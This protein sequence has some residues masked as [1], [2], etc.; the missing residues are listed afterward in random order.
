[1]DTNKLTNE[2]VKRAIEALQSGNKDA[3]FS[4]FAN[5]VAMTDDGNPKNFRSFFD[6]ALGKEYFNTIDRVEND[7]LDIY[8]NFSAGQWGSFDVFFKFH[9]DQEGKIDRIDIGQ[10]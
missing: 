4:L 6:N 9:L 5:E 10:A 1:M 3:W 8:G 2:T 7:G